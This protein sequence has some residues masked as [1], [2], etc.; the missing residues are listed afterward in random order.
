M[1]STAHILNAIAGY[2]RQVRNA[3]DEESLTTR[4]NFNLIKMF[5][6]QWRSVP[7]PL[8]ELNQLILGAALP[9][10]AAQQAQPARGRNAEQQSKGRQ[11]LGLKL[12]AVGKS[13]HQH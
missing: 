4:N 9:H 12:L 8:P 1:I 11:V 2:L 6:S 7:L 3:Y 5:L 13:P 10:Q